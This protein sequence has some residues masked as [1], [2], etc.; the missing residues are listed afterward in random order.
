[1]VVAADRASRTTA[2]TRRNVA[3]KRRRHEARWAH[4]LGGQFIAW[5]E[6]HCVY[7]GGDQI[8]QPFKLLTWQKN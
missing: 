8:G 4:T 3:A 6:A 2:S 5:I 7:P 1:M